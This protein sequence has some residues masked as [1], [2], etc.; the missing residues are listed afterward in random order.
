MDPKKRGTGRLNIL[1]MDRRLMGVFPFLLFG[2]WLPAQIHWHNADADFGQLPSS[3]HIFRTT[4]SLDGLPFLAYVATIRLGDKSLYLGARVGN[5]DRFTPSQY[6]QRENFP[7]LLVNCSFFSFETGRNLSLVI[8][9]GRILAQN[10]NS[11]KGQGRD[12]TLY[13]YPTRSALGINRKRKVD[14]AWIFNDSA[15]HRPYAY[16]KEPVISKG[17]EPNPTILDLGDIEWKWWT[18][19]TAVG[20]GPTLLHDGEIRIT[21]REEQLFAG[22]EEEK[23]P[24]TAMGFTRDDRLII[25]VI[26]GRSPGI[27]DGA[28]LLQEARI[29]RELGCWKA[30]N[31]D[32]GGSSCMLV[33]GKETI[34]PS[35][36]GGERSLPAIF[37]IRKI[38]KRK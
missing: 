29:M 16:E 18:V 8:S 38:P 11:L 17:H 24:R 14:I 15:R 2:G 4:D 6:Y 27:S 25:L 31:L 19:R 37:L 20:G 23:N 28:T 12:S 5:G 26:Q 33:N 30:L 7:V 34:H 13:Y 22:E 1:Q 35:D 32:G 9:D 21:S 36:K 10:I 3:L